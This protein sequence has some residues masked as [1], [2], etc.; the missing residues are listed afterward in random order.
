MQYNFNYIITLTDSITPSLG[1]KELNKTVKKGKKMNSLTSY[2]DAP[3]S[4]VSTAFTIDH[5]F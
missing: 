3:D 5:K 1:L 2:K 4:Y